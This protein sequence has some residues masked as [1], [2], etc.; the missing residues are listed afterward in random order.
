MEI[1]AKTVEMERTQIEIEEMLE[2]AQQSIWDALGIPK[3]LLEERQPKPENKTA[4][5]VL[6]HLEQKLHDAIANHH[7]ALSETENEEVKLTTYGHI[8]ALDG[9]LGYI[10]Y[11]IEEF[12]R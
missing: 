2:K 8:L 12:S 11:L 10:E 1:D 4:V 3:H 9:F 5:Y 6:R 7:R